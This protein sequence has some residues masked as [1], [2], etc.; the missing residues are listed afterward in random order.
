MVIVETV[1]QGR[2]SAVCRTINVVV[3]ICPLSRAV[4]RGPYFISYPCPI[5]KISPSS[6]FAL[7]H[8]QAVLQSVGGDVVHWLVVTPGGHPRGATPLMVVALGWC[9]EERRTHFRVIA[10]RWGRRVWVE[11]VMLDW[12]A[13]NDEPPTSCDDSW[14]EVVGWWYWSKVEGG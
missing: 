11:V 2:G 3:A 4:H 5:P 8:T 14:A 1:L 7:S 13:R 6:Q 10:T 9:A 12:C